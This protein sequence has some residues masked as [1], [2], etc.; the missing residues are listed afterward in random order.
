MDRITQTANDLSGY[1]RF[2]DPVGFDDDLVAEPESRPVFEKSS[3]S[4]L[5]QHQNIE[6]VIMSNPLDTEKALS[7]FG[8]LLGLLGP[9][10]IMVKMILSQ[11]DFGLVGPVLAFGIPI[12][13]LTTLTGYFSGK[14]IGRGVRKI[15]EYPLPS[16]IILSILLGLGWGL[17]TGGIGGLL[18]FGIGA[19]PGAVVGGIAGALALPPFVLLH[20]HLKTGD[21]IERSKFAPL[22]FGIIL[23]LCSLL[24]GR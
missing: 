23:S 18:I 11:D 9:L 7:Y 8:F 15:E 19:I 16:I 21:M 13:L 2:A 4:P 14:T 17:F 3:L 22:A 10:S 1:Y 20:R 24:L 6:S 5:F 12:I